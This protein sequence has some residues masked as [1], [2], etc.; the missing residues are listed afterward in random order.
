MNPHEELRNLSIEEAEELLQVH[1]ATCP[2]PT[3]E[4]MH[5]GLLFSLRSWNAPLNYDNFHEIMACIKAIGPGLSE[6]T[7]RS[8]PISDLWGIVHLGT[9]YVTD[10]ARMQQRKDHVLGP[11][12]LD[13]ELRWLDCIG[14]AVMTYLQFDDA[15]EA[16]TQYD[17]FVIE[18]KENMA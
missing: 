6:S 2:D 11:D 9:S 18:Q 12:E 10:P 16:F 17:A 3:D 1:S 14:Y 4:R 13:V 15:T 7:I 8:R 5:S